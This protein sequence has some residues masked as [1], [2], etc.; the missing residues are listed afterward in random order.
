MRTA[1]VELSSRPEPGN[2]FALNSV[3]P[4]ITSCCVA[5]Q[6]GSTRRVAPDLAVH[7]NHND[8][9]LTWSMLPVTPNLLLVARRLRVFEVVNPVVDG[10]TRAAFLT[11]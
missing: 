7:S 8:G 5:A 11:G 4:Q 1:P 9:I 6:E 10:P 2:N 3:G